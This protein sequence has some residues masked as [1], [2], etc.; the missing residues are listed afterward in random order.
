M[1]W[2]PV[3]TNGKALGA[4]A[5]VAHTGASSLKH[6]ESGADTGRLLVAPI[7]S[8][9]GRDSRVAS[10]ATVRCAPRWHHGSGI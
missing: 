6:A 1:S 8:P 2:V 10:A 7:G 9:M 5:H 4:A 3:R